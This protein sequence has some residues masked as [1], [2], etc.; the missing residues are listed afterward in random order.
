[1]KHLLILGSG[2][3]EHAIAM[4][5]SYSNIMRTGSK[6][7]YAIHCLGSTRNPGLMEVCTHSGGSYRTGDITDPLTVVATC[8]QAEASLVIIG[9]E[10]PLE[11][12]VA[13]ALRAVGTS[14]VGPCRSLA[15]I[16]TSKTCARD[17][18]FARIP[19]A[20]PKYFVATTVEQAAKHIQELNGSYVIKADGL[21]GGKGVL[22][23]GEHLHSDA[24]AIAYCSELL[25]ASTK[26]EPR[27]VIEEKLEGEEFSLMTLT[28]GTTCLH[29]PPLQDHKRAFAGDTGPN[30]GGMGSYTGTEGTLPFLSRYE[31][32]TAKAYNE[33]V[34]RELRNATGVP[35]RGI[36]YGGFMATAG[37][38]KI[39]EY[40][41]RFG[42]PEALNLMRLLK[43]DGIE[44]FERMADGTLD[45]YDL[46]IDH[47]ASVCLYLVPESYPAGKAIGD[48]VEIGPIGDDLWLCYGSIDRTEEGALVTA[49]SRT[50]ALVAT[51]RTIAE[52]RRQVLDS[53][54]VITGKLRYR[55]DIGSDV[56][57]DKRIEHMSRL[58]SPLRIA[59]LGSTNGT[60]LDAIING[61][62]DTSVPTH[63]KMVISD[64]EDAPILQRAK[65]NG[66]PATW[67]AKKG[68]ARE[69]E[70]SRLCE[71]SEIELI[72][73]IGYMRILGPQ[74]CERWKGRI[75]NVHPSL[76]PEFAGTMDS[77]THTLA[78][79]R[80]HRTGNAVTGCTVHLVTDQV[81]AG[82]ILLQK[83]C[84]ISADDTPAALKSKVQELEGTAL[85]EC[86][87]ASYSARG[88]LS[89]A[90]TRLRP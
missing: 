61:I 21:A 69:R 49:G 14:V 67:I 3:R 65:R 42:D 66:I 39:I 27:C 56:L 22:I 87:A 26:G 51:G 44:L 38:V 84:M 11:R 35:Y 81:D 7:P 45:G 5:L 79:E 2:A 47:S 33:L 89:K 37:G 53:I 68:V 31:L 8:T 36:L 32:E 6:E 1:M 43:S 28:D 48:E 63:I 82:P 90:T 40:N 57:L 64:R 71:E 24:Q 13:D 29:L 80:M 83:Q 9:P 12:G 19:E 55:S 85:C 16:E 4:Q 46:R 77:D 70:I 54:G 88:D 23:A 25:T 58:R 78:I 34:V 75:M 30:T 41:A 62:A 76:L 18:L 52:A 59:V 17:F 73:L 10:A 86:I 15:R 20:C 60:D 50:A 72:V 74:F